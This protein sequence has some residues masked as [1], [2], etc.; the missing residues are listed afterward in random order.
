[1]VSLV[2]FDVTFPSNV[3]EQLV[4]DCPNKEG[5]VITKK[6]NKKNVIRIMRVQTLNI[7][8]N[9]GNMWGL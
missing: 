2:S 8:P 6:N 9:R 5:I 7:S 3:H 1:M 4:D